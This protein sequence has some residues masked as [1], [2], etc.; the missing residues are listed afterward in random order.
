MAVRTRMEHLTAEETGDAPMSWP[1]VRLE[2][3]EIKSPM[4]FEVRGGKLAID[5][6]HDSIDMTHKEW[7]QIVAQVA[8]LWKGA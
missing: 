8:A 5:T 1:T 7:E 2:Q 3:S 6:R 4:R